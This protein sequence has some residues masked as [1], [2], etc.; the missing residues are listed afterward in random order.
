MDA[1]R[2]GR[3]HSRAAAAADVRRA[4]GESH[5][6]GR[7][8]AAGQ[9]RRG[10]ERPLAEGQWPFPC[11]ATHPHPRGMNRRAACWRDLGRARGGSAAGGR[12]S[13]ESAQLRVRL[14]R[15]GVDF[16]SPSPS[17][18]QLALT[19]PLPQLVNRKLVGASCARGAEAIV[20]SRGPNQSQKADGE[21][22]IAGT[23]GS[24]ARGGACK[25][26]PIAAVRRAWP[27]GAGC[28][29]GRRVAAA[30]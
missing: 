29:K 16:Q 9:G 23:E 10:G 5:R 21:E 2:W 12:G 26:E 27:G 24:G 20:R 22:P 1:G 3:T 13:R 7:C 30:S 11:P 4:A 19:P 14:L 17:P 18:W 8:P 6:R 28:A 25:E 15:S